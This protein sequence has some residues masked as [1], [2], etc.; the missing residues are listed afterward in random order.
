MNITFTHLTMQNFCGVKE[1]DIDFYD[2]TIIKGQ[3]KSGKTTVKNAIYWVLFNRLADGSSPDN[4][5]PH[6]ENGV[7]V[8]MIDISVTLTMDADGKEIAVKKTQKQNW[9]TDRTTQ[10]QK[11]KGNVNEY[12]INGIPKK[13]KDFAD[14]MTQFIAPDLFALCTN[15]QVFLRLDNKKRRA[16]LFDMIDGADTE[17]VDSDPKF[18]GLKNDLMDGTVEELIARSKKAISSYKDKL[19]EIPARIDELNLQ[20]KVLTEDE[21]AEL[22]GE[23]QMQ[24][25]ELARLDTIKDT[26]NEIAERAS[27]ARIRLNEIETSMRLDQQKAEADLNLRQQ[28]L[29]NNLAMY[30]NQLK[31]MQESISTSQAQIETHNMAIADYERGIKT[32]Q[33]KE[34]DEK[35]LSCPT[36]GRKYPDSK[37]ESIRKHFEDEKASKIESLESLITSTKELIAVEEEKIIKTNDDIQRIQADISELTGELA[38]VN[39]EMTK[40]KAPKSVSDNAEYLSIT[41]DMAKWQA[42]E[43]QIKSAHDPDLLIKV[44]NRIAEIKLALGREQTNNSYQQRIEELQEEQLK[45]SQKIADEERKVD[46][47]Q[48]YQIAKVNLLTERINAFFSVIKWQMF[49]AQINGGFAEVCTP[50]VNGTSYDGLLN[51]G[52]KILAEIDLCQAFQKANNIVCPILIDDTESLDEWRV[53]NLDNQLICIRRTDD[54]VLAV[55]KIS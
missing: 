8:D 16:L 32:E 46:L 10:E 21:R 1:L 9:V 41:A 5:R 12:E 38:N 44:T 11:F 33:S 45:T 28:T 40:K 13:E 23:L 27:K 34:F 22:N 53:P 6:D 2:R 48:A 7:D 25:D 55:E 47:L 30:G 49:K 37:Q 51:H 35:S 36:C 17:V 54:K 29:T 43:E 3:N 50:L 19:V 4:I 15:P 31:T 24:E 14:Y 18:A 52:D 26:L 39:E 20:I 42:E